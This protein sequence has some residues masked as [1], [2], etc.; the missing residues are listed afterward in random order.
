MGGLDSWRQVRA[1][2]T[3]GS[4]SGGADTG[5]PMAGAARGRGVM[6]EAGANQPSLRVMELRSS[7]PHSIDSSDLLRGCGHVLIL[8]AGHVY[9]LRRTRE[10]K[11]ILT[12]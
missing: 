4:Q 8:H 3:A 10:N 12:K 9:T 2:R 5:R 1:I 11:L 6:P 7:L